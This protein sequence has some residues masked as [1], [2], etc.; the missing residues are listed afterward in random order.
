MLPYQ[1]IEL[2]EKDKTLLTMSKGTIIYHVQDEAVSWQCWLDDL[3][4]SVL[5][6]INKGDNR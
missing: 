3:L 4:V 2:Y 5:I 1:F 6:T